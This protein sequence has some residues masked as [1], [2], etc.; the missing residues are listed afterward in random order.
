MLSRI[1]Y[2]SVFFYCKQIFSSLHLPSLA[3]IAIG[4]NYPDGAKFGWEKQYM[5]YVSSFVWSVFGIYFMV[6]IKLYCII[7]IILLYII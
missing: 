5:Y 4:G 1:S 6:Y 3:L 2:N 7:Y